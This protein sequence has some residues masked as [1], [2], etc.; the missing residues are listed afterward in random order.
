LGVRKFLV[1]GCANNKGTIK[2]AKKWRIILFLVAADW[3]GARLPDSFNWPL[4]GLALILLAVPIANMGWQLP[5]REAT[6]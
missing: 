3:N 5:H 2:T 4:F 1:Q 6:G